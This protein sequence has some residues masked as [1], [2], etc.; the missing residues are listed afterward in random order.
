MIDLDS[1][2]GSL[3]GLRD[4]ELR[5]MSGEATHQHFKGGLYRLVGRVC[6]CETGLPMRMLESAQI[7]VLYEH[8]VPYDSEM[9]MREE[10]EFFGRVEWEAKCSP[11]PDR[12][13]L[14]KIYGGVAFVKRFRAIGQG[15]L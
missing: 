6:D 4:A 15:W 5:L 14:N 7:A 10:K 12:K 3:L 2:H 8:M 11:G 1:P 13:R 9:F